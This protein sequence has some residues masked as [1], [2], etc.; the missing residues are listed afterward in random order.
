MSSDRFWFDERAADAAERFFGRVLVHVKGEWAGQPL[1][2]EP[3]QAENVI[4]ESIEISGTIRFMKAE[5]REQ[6]HA[7]IERA[8]EVARALGGDYTLQ[9]ELGGTQMIND[10]EIAGLIREVATDLLG[11]DHIQSRKP[12][13]GSEDFG[14]FSE[15][16]P[17][18]MFGLGCQIEGDERKH[19][20]PRFDIDERCLPLGTAI[21][22]EAA[23]RLLRR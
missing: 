23:L 15:L 3:W 10:E 4:P 5:V 22:A 9:I 21:L 13:M 8:L 6:I 11:A 7:E 19:H 17:G 18:A 16:A 1:E 14:D 20:N 12:D 2:L